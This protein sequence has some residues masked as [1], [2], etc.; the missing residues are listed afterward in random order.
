MSLTASRGLMDAG[1]WT[2][3]AMTVAEHIRAIQD[4]RSE[5]NAPPSAPAGA[6]NAAGQFL[7]YALAALDRSGTQGVQGSVSR[8]IATG[9][10][11]MAGISSLSIAVNVIRSAQGAA[12]IEN[13]DKVRQEIDALSKSLALL[14]S[15]SLETI[16]SV[17]LDRLRE[18]F[19]ELGRAGRVD[20]AAAIASNERPIRF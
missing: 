5:H 2:T 15:P 16:D 9:A 10:P 3:V 14:E 17:E 8:A 20:R 19:K 4:A 11:T 7:G 13:L 18:F 12:S 1:R 6:L